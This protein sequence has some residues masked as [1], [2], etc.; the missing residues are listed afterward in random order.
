M[1]CLLMLLLVTPYV[2]ISVELELELHWDKQY[3]VLLISN[4]ELS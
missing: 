1:D 4:K 2:W 3:I